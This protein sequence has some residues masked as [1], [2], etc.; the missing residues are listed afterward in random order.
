MNNAQ[1]HLRL[2]NCLRG[3][4]GAGQMKIRSEQDKNRK[5]HFCRV[6]PSDLNFSN[7]PTFTSGSLNELLH[8]SMRGDPVVFATG[9]NLYDSEGDLVAAG[10]LSKPLS[11]NYGVVS[12][13]KA[14][15]DF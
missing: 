13:I 8:T 2:V 6:N 4:S 7:N 3:P 15:L 1:N 5:Y 12:I 11:N 14:I 10:K 9:I